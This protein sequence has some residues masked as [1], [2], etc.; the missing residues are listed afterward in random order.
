MYWTYRFST[1]EI[2]RQYSLQ[3]LNLGL[4]VEIVLKFRNFQP[5]YPYEIYSLRRKKG[6]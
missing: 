4:T 1:H 3:N 2:I 5:R 6:V